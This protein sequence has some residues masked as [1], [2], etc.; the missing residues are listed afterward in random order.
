MFAGIVIGKGRVADLKP[1]AGGVRLVIDPAGVVFNPLPGGGDSVCV[2][3]CCLTLA[4]SA[5][6]KPG[7]LGFDVIKETLDKTR[8]GSLKVGD[9]VNLE[10]SLTPSTPIGG[11]F[12][13][14]HVDGVG[15]IT[16]VSAQP[17][18][19]RVTVEPPAHLMPYM[20]PKG[21]VGIDGVSLTL[22]AVSKTEI[23]VALIPTT[24]RLTTLGQ[25]KVGDPVN[26]EADMIAKTIV[27]WLERVLEEP[28][29]AKPGLTIQKLRDAG[30]VA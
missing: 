14:G 27:S 2:S 10:T 5:G 7:I 23:E 3:G 16:R 24:L 11:H 19:W 22:A 8:L 21:S 13:Q 26:L 9:E 1:T 25:A 6:E 29:E 20:T 12:V 30:F 28:G 15:R 17:E 4:P 18:E